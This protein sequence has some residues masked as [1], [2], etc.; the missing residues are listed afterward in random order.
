MLGRKTCAKRA[1]MPNTVPARQRTTTVNGIIVAGS[2]SVDEV[3]CTCHNQKVC[4][5]QNEQSFQSCVFTV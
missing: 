2:G 5:S 1:D 4:S 3:E